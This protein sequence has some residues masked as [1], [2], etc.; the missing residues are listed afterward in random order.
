MD[1][2]WEDITQH[3]YDNIKPISGRLISLVDR[4]VKNKGKVENIW[5]EFEMNE[6]MYED[7]FYGYQ[8]STSMFKMNIE[9]WTYIE[10]LRLKSIFE[11]ENLIIFCDKK[12]RIGAFSNSLNMTVPKIKFGKIQD[13]SLPVI[14]EYCMTNSDSYGMMT[15]TI[16]D[17]ITCSGLFQVTLEIEDLILLLPKNI[18][19]SDYSKYLDKNIY[20]SGNI[21]ISEDLNH[22]HNQSIYYRIPY[23]SQRRKQWWKFWE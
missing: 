16:D 7:P 1:H 9:L 3:L 22:D 2:K 12:D 21:R 19:P 17:H 15:G 10:R 11:L 18:D 4:G 5:I 14:V 20:N 23:S 13:Y 8:S 6:F